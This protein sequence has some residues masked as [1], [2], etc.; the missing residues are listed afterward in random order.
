MVKKEPLFGNKKLNEFDIGKKLGKGSYAIVKLCT[1]KA[2][3][4]K[5][6]LKI[7]EKYK[8]QS[9]SKR[10]NVI[11]E[12]KNLKKLDHINIIKFITAINTSK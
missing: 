10:K 3:E 9:K 7:Y 1:E 4:R 5:F 2:T 8:L 11:N 12:I 6:V